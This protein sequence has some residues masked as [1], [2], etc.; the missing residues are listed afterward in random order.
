MVP[1]IEVGFAH[2]ATLAGA[3][4]NS[5]NNTWESPP[6]NHCVKAPIAHGY[7]PRQRQEKPTE[8]APQQEFIVDDEV[9]DSS[10]HKEYMS[11]YEKG[12]EKRIQENQQYL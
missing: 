12:R 3:M 9:R 2:R 1:G 4:V 5:P 8:N 7:L 11:E 6:V 10:K